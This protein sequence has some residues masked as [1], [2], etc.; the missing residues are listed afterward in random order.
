MMRFWKMVLTL[1]FLPLALSYRAAGVIL[2]KDRARRLFYDAIVAG[3]ARVLAWNIP[4]LKNG[5]PFSVFSD[6]FARV[7]SRMP[8]ETIRVTIRTA[9]TFQINITRCQFVEVFAL[10]GMPELTPAL[11]QG[12]VTFCDKFQPLI[13]F[14]RFHTLAAGDGFC[15]HTYYFRNDRET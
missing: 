11:C 9:D 12:D 5:Q 2:G 3:S 10:L 6:R 1:F 7:L 14:E 8:F 4:T 15:D 13:R